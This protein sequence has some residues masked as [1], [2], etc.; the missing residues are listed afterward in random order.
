MP[1]PGIA[2]LR[3][4]PRSVNEPEERKKQFLISGQCPTAKTA[5][6][7]SSAAS[8]ANGARGSFARLAADA[9]FV[10]VD[11]RESRGTSAM[12]RGAKS[13]LWLTQLA[14]RG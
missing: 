1:L 13:A 2:S 9:A 12:G 6:R 5:D 11:V 4:R 7:L 14:Q 10:R 3:F 8:N